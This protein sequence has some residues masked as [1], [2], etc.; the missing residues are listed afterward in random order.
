M[1]EHAYRHV[2]I[3]LTESSD[4]EERIKRDDVEVICLNKQ[5]GNDI[6]VHFKIWLL[7]RKLAPEI[8]HTYNIATLEYNIV[9]FLAGVKKRIHAEHGRDI[10][11]LDGS[12]K[13]YQ[14]LRRLINPFVTKWIPVSKELYDWLI[15]TVGLP[16]AK[17]RLIYNGIDLNLYRSKQHHLNKQFVVGTVGRM[18]KV[19]DQLSII[20]AAEK[21]LTDYPDLKNTL[22]FIVVGSGELYQALYEYIASNNMEESIE[23]LG[24]RNDVALILQD[25]DVFILTSL[26]EGIPLT[27]LEAMATAL[28]IIATEVGGNPELIDNDINGFLIKPKDIDNIACKIKY[29]LDHPE[30]VVQHGINSREKVE[31]NFSLQ[32]MT[33]KYLQLY[34]G[35]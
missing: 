26:A 31:N 13:K 14:Y 10:Y 28:P 4:L 20:K 5:A 21:L 35:L 12:N 17:V 11:D 19:K 23:L 3:S 1:P 18:A 24:A 15:A 22:K 30:S 9:A 6:K 7:L 33:E 16:R 27:I 25:F 34:R 29:Y 8:I 32:V 2:I